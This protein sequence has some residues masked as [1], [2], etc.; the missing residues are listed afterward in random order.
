MTKWIWIFLLFITTVSYADGIGDFSDFGAN[1]ATQI[2]NDTSVFDNV[3]KASNITVQGALD[4]LDELVTANVPASATATCTPKKLAY[5]SNYFYVCV[6][7]NTWR[8]VA[9]TTWTTSSSCSGLLL[10]DGTSF[11]LLQDGSSKLLLEGCSSTGTTILM[12]DGSDMLNENGSDTML[13]E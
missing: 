7:T 4:Q 9:I 6:G 8:R 2:F 5:D 1:H 3:L 12:E 13:I 10:Q 11:L